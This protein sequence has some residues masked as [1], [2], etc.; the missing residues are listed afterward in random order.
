[1][2]KRARANR[3]AMSG[4]RRGKAHDK[5]KHYTSLRSGYDKFEHIESGS[6]LEKRLDN[7]RLRRHSAPDESKKLLNEWKPSRV[8]HKRKVYKVFDN[9]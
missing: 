2:G 9:V 8:L 6:S 1:M 5:S 7:T 3:K 4:K